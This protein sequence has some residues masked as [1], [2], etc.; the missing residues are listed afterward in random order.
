MQ[1]IPTLWLHLLQLFVEKLFIC[2]NGTF[3]L[4]YRWLIFHLRNT[5]RLLGF[6]WN[7]AC[8]YIQLKMQC[9]ERDD[10]F[11]CCL[12]L[13]T[14]TA[15]ITDFKPVFNSWKNQ[16]APSDTYE[17]LECTE[18]CKQYYHHRCFKSLGKW[19]IDGQCVT[20]DCCGRIIRLY[21]KTVVKRESK[22]PNEP[23]WVR[24]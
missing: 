23:K 21:E 24:S 3:A 1:K 17:A 15:D 10:H 4:L 6:F 18:K 12:Q 20:P 13:P 14:C 8:K 22:M 5:W 7:L 2:A 19:N 11:Y 16:T 9:S